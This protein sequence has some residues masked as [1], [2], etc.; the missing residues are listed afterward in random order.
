MPSFASPHP[1]YQQSFLC[2]VQELL[3]A[4]ED[5]KLTGLTVF[6]E[7]TH[8]IEELADPAA[9]AAFAQ[10]L[11]D[12]ALIGTPRPEGKVPET[13]LWWVDGSDLLGRLSIRHE[14][15]DALREFGGHI[16]Y[17][18]RPS[19]RRQGHAKAMLAAALPIARGIGIDPALLTCGAEN[20]GSRRVI[21]SNGG[22]LEDQREGELRF[23]VPTTV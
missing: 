16:G 17:V 19:V 12:L 23:W 11:R 22:V 8:T 15:T 4:G 10:R 14:L 6:G 9:F 21:E 1:R 13:M 2:S 18:V 3:D 7:E 5:Q 20:T